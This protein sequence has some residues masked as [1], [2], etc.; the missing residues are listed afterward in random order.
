MPDPLIQEDIPLAGQTTLGLGGPARFFISCETEQDLRF[1]LAFAER[2]RLPLFVLGGGSNVIIADSGFDGVVLRITMRGWEVRD[3]GANELLWVAAGERWDD[4][5]AFCVHRGLGGLEC[6]SGIP[7]TAGATPIQ[8]VGAYGQDVAGTI[9]QVRVIHRPT[10]ALLTFAGS[11]CGFGYRSSRFKT[12]DAGTYII[13]GVSFRLRKNARPQIRYPELERLL[14]RE[15]S[16]EQA[17]PGAPALQCVRGAVLSLR[18]GKGMVIDP[19]DPDTKSVGSF[20]MNPIITQ[21]AFAT[22]VEQWRATG[23][24]TEVPAF[25]AGRARKI[26]AAWLV[27][28]AGFVRGMVRG[29][30]G[31]SEKHALALVNRGG[32]AAELLAFAHEIRAGVFGRFGVLLEIEPVVAGTVESRWGESPE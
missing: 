4:I 30:V 6:L 20:F 15:G 1:A 31:I 7:G 9:H 19:A 28:Q 8:N 32:T 14:V 12:S 2:K 16:L 21:E 22:I 29:G 27:E 11:D 5:V 25:P 10:G 18:R 24:S 3:D 26:S 13:T 17:R 23:H